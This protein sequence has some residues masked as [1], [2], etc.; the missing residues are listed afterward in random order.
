MSLPAPS[1][2]ESD[3]RRRDEFEAVV[4]RAVAR[5]PEPFARQLDS[6]AI[7]VED[8]P[9]PEQQRPGILLFGLYEG[10]PRTAWGATGAPV[11]SRITIYR[12]AHERTYH[13]PV[14]RAEAVEGTV[15][16]EVAHHLGIDEAT[17]RRIEA[18]RRR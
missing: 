15:L 11:P 16:H 13:D 10:V 8:E 12:L 5:I 18:E 7:I 1:P 4:E 3:E 14:V 2:E 9:R 17:I 6:V